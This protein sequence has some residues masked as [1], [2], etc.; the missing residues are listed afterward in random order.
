MYVA[1]RI[2]CE[3]LGIHPNTLRSLAD[4]GKIQ[5]YITESGHRRYDVDDYLSDKNQSGDSKSDPLSFLESVMKGQDPRGLSSIYELVTAIND[6]TELSESDWE[7][8]VAEVTD[9]LKHQPVSLSESLNAGKTLAEY[10]HAK[11]KHIELKDGGTISLSA[12][13]MPLSIEEIEL[14]KEKFNGD[15]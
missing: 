6:F 3:Q 15:F 8:I 13:N 12:H 4:T 14:F 11:R 7:E 9:N 10:Q 5:H 1:S 2:A